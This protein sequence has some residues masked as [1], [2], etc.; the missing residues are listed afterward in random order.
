MSVSTPSRSPEMPMKKWC[1]TGKVIGPQAGGPDK[2][3][4]CSSKRAD[5]HQLKL[6]EL[7][8]STVVAIDSFVYDRYTCRQVQHSLGG[9]R[10]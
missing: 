10:T 2:Q 1:S 5:P 3:L 7:L 9:L 8:I 4:Q 6:D